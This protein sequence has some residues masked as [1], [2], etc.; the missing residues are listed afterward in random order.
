MNTALFRWAQPLL[1][2][3][4]MFSAALRGAEQPHVGQPALVPIKDTLAQVKLD[5]LAAVPVQHGGRYKPL[6]SFAME[7]SDAIAYATSFGNGHTPLSS[8]LDLLFCHA[9]YD[10]QPIARV[11]HTE[12]RR[13]LALVLPEAERALLLDEGKITPKRLNDQAVRDELEKLGRLT[14]KTKAISQVQSAQG[15]LDPGNVLFQLRLFP[16]PAGAHDD[17]WRDPA[18]LGTD[19][20][21]S[22]IAFVV[23]ARAGDGSVSAFADQSWTLL[24]LTPETAAKI[25]LERDELVNLNQHFLWPLWRAAAAGKLDEAAAKKLADDPAQAAALGLDEPEIVTAALRDLSRRWSTLGVSDEDLADKSLRPALDAAITKAITS[26]NT[27]GLGWRAARHGALPGAELQTRIDTFVTA[28]TALRE[29]YA[30]DRS[31][32][33]LEPLILTSELELTYWKWQGNIHWVWLSLLLAVPFLAMGGIGRQR[34]AL[35]IGYVLLVTG[36]AGQLT[37]FIVRAELAQ[38]IPVSNLYESMAAAS[39]LATWI[40]LLG[41]AGMSWSRRVATGLVLALVAVLVVVLAVAFLSGWPWAIIIPAIGIVTGSSIIMVLS[42]RM[43]PA[44]RGSLG[45]GASLFGC[46]II[47]AQILLE[48]H[49]INAFISPAMPILSEFWLRVHTSCII[50]SYGLISLGGLMSLTYLIMRIW[51]PWNDPRSEAW[52]RTTFAIDAVA[53]LVLW[54]G[55]C[56]GAVWAAVSWGRPWGWDP[57]EVFALL[58]WVVYIGLVHLRVAL[59]PQKRGLATAWV[60]LGAFIVMIF[61]WYWVNVQLAGLHSYA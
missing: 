25:G 42:N 53:M 29:L 7:V 22:F 33:G 10:D 60:A 59:P 39:L 57:K 20:T 40:A 28:T 32:R 37:A 2:L 30:K 46:L 3:L 61:N 56:L 34:W 12:L 58:T 31:T 35:I 26:W 48:Y 24:P 5:G 55:L 51:L 50:A 54:V 47:F 8:L 18:D 13:D 36:F 21:T 23:A 41:E 52:D 17:H 38:R 44:G 19:F 4:L 1:A 11:K 49:D 15:M 6:H 16:V 9:D 27:L 14:T 43:G 45:L